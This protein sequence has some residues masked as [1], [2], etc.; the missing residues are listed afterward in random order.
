[1]PN[2][3]VVTVT[4]T[5]FTVPDLA[6]ACAFFRDVPWLHDQRND[7]ARWRDRGADDRRAR[8]RT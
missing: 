2:H 1:M 6:R 3:S 4:H 7:T 8:R 5:G